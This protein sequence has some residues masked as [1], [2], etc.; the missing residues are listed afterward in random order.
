MGWW[1]W[2]LKHI[3][4]HS[5][6]VFLTDRFK[7]GILDYLEKSKYFWKCINCYLVFV[8]SAV[9]FD[10][11]LQSSSPRWCEKIV[12]C[13]HLVVKLWRCGHLSLGCELLFSRRG[14]APSG[15][16]P[17]VLPLRH[18]CG[19]GGGT[20]LTREFTSTPPVYFIFSIFS[21]VT[22]LM[23]DLLCWGVFLILLELFP[24]WLLSSGV[25]FARV[26]RAPPLNVFFFLDRNWCDTLPW[27]WFPLFHLL[28]WCGTGGV[29]SLVL[30]NCIYFFFFSYFVV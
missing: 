25:F 6:I 3:V 7:N 20:W 17:A 14:T 21:G 30:L 10:A 12:K 29:S 13:C 19:P 9:L 26:P 15:L 18:G 22:L 16:G 2:H 24:G 1:T 8:W 11:V 28:R 23:F 27:W 5:K 4:T